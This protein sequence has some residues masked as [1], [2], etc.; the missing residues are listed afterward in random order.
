MN[1]LIIY[2]SQDGTTKRYAE[3]FAAMMDFPV[4]S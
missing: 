4:I 3:K 1:N 2:G